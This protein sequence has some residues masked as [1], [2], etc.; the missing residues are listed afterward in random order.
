MSHRWGKKSRHRSIVG[1]ALVIVFALVAAACSSSNSSSSPAPSLPADAIENVAISSNDWPF[2]LVKQNGQSLDTITDSSGATMPKMVINAIHRVRAT[3][4]ADVAASG[5]DIFLQYR[6]PNG[7][8]LTI[9]KIPVS[10]GGMVNQPWTPGLERTDLRE[11]RLA[12]MTIEP[13]KTTVFSTSRTVTASG[14]LEHS[15]TLINNTSNDLDI[16]IP[17]RWDPV[18]EAWVQFT[19]SLSQGE[20]KTLV[21]VNP[22]LGTGFSMTLNRQ[23]CLFGCDDYFMDFRWAADG[24]QPCI[25]NQPNFAS[26]GAFTITLSDDINGQGGGLVGGWKVGKIQG[27]LDGPGAATEA[28]TFTTRTRTGIWLTNHPVK[29]AVIVYAI[30]VVVMMTALVTIELLPLLGIFGAALGEVGETALIPGETAASE[31]GTGLRPKSAFIESPKVNVFSNSEKL[32]MF[33]FPET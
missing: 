22:P 1:V 3:V 16:K 32:Q 15:I 12:A 8:W 17:L 26:G 28:C 6:K 20:Q 31:T 33:L 18:Q 29:G 7:T 23:S 25:D 9:R 24:F 27:P 11:Y 14:N 4:P 30:V 13:T 10:F 2:E 21:Y 19:V 5:L